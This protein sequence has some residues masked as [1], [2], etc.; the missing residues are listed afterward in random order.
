MEIDKPV[1]RKEALQDTSIS[2]CR[3]RC[4]VGRLNKLGEK[5]LSKRKTKANCC[6]K[7]KGIAAILCFTVDTECSV[8][9][10]HL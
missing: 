9:S 7:A 10:K 4:K 1:S 3:S 2:H 8:F 6:S 5:C